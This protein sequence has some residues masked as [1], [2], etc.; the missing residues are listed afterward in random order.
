M[1]VFARAVSPQ[2]DF[3]RWSPISCLCL[4]TSP[5]APFLRVCLQPQK[6]RSKLEEGWLARYGAVRC[7]AS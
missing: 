7:K 6:S 5:L 2:R 1:A 3:A 4:E